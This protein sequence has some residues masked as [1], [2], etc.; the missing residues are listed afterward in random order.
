MH[1][2]VPWT[3]DEAI[4]FIFLL[5]STAVVVAVPLVYGARANKRDPL[6][7]AVLAGT[8]AT[9]VA[10]IATVLFTVAL[11]TGGVRSEVTMHW[12]VRFLYV[13]V[14]IG[15]GILLLAFL[16]LLRGVSRNR[17]GSL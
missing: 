9:G 1:W 2:A 14:A 4:D 13:T 11:H 8:G 6:A 17:E 12:I 16:R 7:R 3:T 5:V 15:K 10:F